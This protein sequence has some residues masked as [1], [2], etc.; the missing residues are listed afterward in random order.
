MI[1]KQVLGILFLLSGTLLGCAA[2]AV[3]VIII[4]NAGILNSASE[5]ELHS[6]LDSTKYCIIL[7]TLATSLTAL[8][9][10]AARTGPEVKEDSAASSL[11]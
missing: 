1:S 7:L 8:G 5:G 6:A 2:F 3:L 4:F 10:L 11:R 9:L